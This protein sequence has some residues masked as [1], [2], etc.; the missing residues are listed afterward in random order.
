[1][2]I[3]VPTRARPNYLAVTLESLMAQ[4]RAAGAEVLV[5]QDGRDPNTEAVARQHG[6][7]LLTLEPPAGLNSARNLAVRASDTEFVVF[8]DDDVRVAPGWLSAL[9]EG[10]RT[11]PEADVFGGPIHA[12][13]EGGGPR[14]C[15]R[16]SAPITTLWLGQEDV[17]AEFVWGANMAI[18][19]AA[20]ERVGP[21]DEGLSGRGDE[22]DW[23]RRLK[24]AGGRVRYVAAAAVTHRRT[25]ADSRL[26]ALSRAAYALGRSARRND[27]RK[28]A[29][30]PP[31]QEIRVLLGC[32]WHTVRRRCAYGIVM[33]AHT[34]GRLR[35]LLAER[36][37]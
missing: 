19:R 31:R 12:E 29:A 21:F 2:S 23:E 37:E 16:E 20:F 4:A 24:A 35:E 36:R 10:V 5:V 22:E 8:L 15:G 27:V 34:L 30:P 32:V 7:R 33:A 6:T 25:A 9:L 17:E 1:M 14:A 3:A 28:A 13:L 11:A 18:R 26:R